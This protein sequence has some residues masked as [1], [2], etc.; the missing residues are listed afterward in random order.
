MLSHGKILLIVVLAAA[1]CGGGNDT[2]TADYDAVAVKDLGA[3]VDEA[4]GT[5]DVA[6]PDGFSLETDPGGPS[7]DPCQPCGSVND[8]GKG[9]L[10]TSVGDK[11]HCLKQCD[12]DGDCPSGYICY[13]ASSKGLQCIPLSFDCVP[14]TFEGCNDGRCCNL[15]SGSSSA[16]SAFSNVESGSSTA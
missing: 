4:I 14:C 8:C 6:D 12:G 3:T 7:N 2:D 11:K 13:Q 16:Y 10:C 1:G 15:E 9:Y 5:V